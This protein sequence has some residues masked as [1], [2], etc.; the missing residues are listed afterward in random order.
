MD[1]LSC[2]QDLIKQG[3]TDYVNLLHKS[4]AQLPFESVLVFDDEHC[5]YLLRELGW[6]KQGRI[7]QTRLH[8]ALKNGK[9]WIEEDWTEDGIATYFLEQNVPRE[10][11]V[12]GF[13][14]PEMRPYT[15]FAVA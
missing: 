8:V 15:E 4:A 12:L 10:D 3:L 5:Q 6:T 9:I 11:I 1:K 14:P 7:R 13:Q 2:Y